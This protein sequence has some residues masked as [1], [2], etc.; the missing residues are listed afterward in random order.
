MG[1]DKGVL[2]S[3]KKPRLGRIPSFS[4]IFF[5]LQDGCLAREEST[6]LHCIELFWTREQQHLIRNN[7]VQDYNY[8]NIKT[9]W[10]SC[11]CWETHSI[12]MPPFQKSA[13]LWWFGS[14]LSLLFLARLFWPGSMLWTINKLVFT[15]LFKVTG[16][17]KCSQI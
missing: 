17:H 6:Y 13:N 4:G 2:S 7:N 9:F 10:I 16:S 3:S 5:F 12:Q 1:R 14:A 15:S 8:P 11:N